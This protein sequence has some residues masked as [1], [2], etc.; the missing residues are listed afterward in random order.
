MILVNL[1]H[2]EAPIRGAQQW[3]VII[4]LTLKYLGIGTVWD[5]L[6]I[7]LKP[8]WINPRA[9]FCLSV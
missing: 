8:M 5:M 3:T 4:F 7:E 1:R 9:D 6:C 2:A